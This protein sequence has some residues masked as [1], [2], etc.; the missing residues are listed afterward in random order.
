MGG[1]GRGHIYLV[2]LSVL[3]RQENH[4]DYF[5]TQF[6]FETDLEASLKI[7]SCICR[8]L[9]KKEPRARI[10][11]CLVSCMMVGGSYKYFKDHAHQ[12][13]STQIGLAC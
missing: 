5:C 9:L 8:H 3:R 11:S 13:R 12:K 7:V 1:G 2:F 10:L 4:C 6:T